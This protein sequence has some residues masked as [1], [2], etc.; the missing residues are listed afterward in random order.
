V[1]EEPPSPGSP[2]N[3]TLLLQTS[4]D[5]NPRE[6]ISD[7]GRNWHQARES[8]KSLHKASEEATRILVIDCSV[9]S[10]D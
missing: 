10:I 6:I 5:E 7:R 4:K 8:V 1:E 2:A 3:K 9:R